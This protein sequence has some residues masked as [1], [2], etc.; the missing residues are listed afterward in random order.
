MRSI[1]S[2]TTALVAILLVA[3]CSTGGPPSTSPGDGPATSPSPVPSPSAAPSDTTTP[4]PAASPEDVWTEAAELAGVSLATVTAGGP[5]VLV[6]GCANPDPEGW[7]LEA[8]VWTSADGRTLTPA[9]V[10][11]PEGA[12]IGRIVAVPGGYVALGSERVKLAGEG[13]AL[14]RA[15]MWR[16]ADGRDWR[17]VEDETFT[18]RSLGD[19]I[20]WNGGLLALGWNAPYASEYHGFALWRSS[21]GDDWQLVSSETLPGIELVSGLL[22]GPDG[23]VAWGP[24]STWVSGSEMGGVVRSIDGIVWTRTPDQASLAKAEILGVALE[25]GRYVAVG[26]S[27]LPGEEPVVPAAWISEDGV[28]WTRVAPPSGT[29][30]GAMRDVWSTGTGFVASGW[31]MRSPD[32]DMVRTYWASTDGTDWAALEPGTFV[33]D[34]PGMEV[35]EPA[36]LGDGR[37]AVGYQSDPVRSVVWVNPA[38]GP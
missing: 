34:A 27:G 16:S 21:D 30:A 10:E 5:G 6:G 17:R 24:R 33:P 26:V 9:T 19:V 38:A 14:L 3:A 32:T 22:V 8:G 18:N 4:S 35:S 2:A 12:G 29:A 37:V 36:A 20:P 28:T 11:R 1:G 15:A 31:A 7:C 25:D 13:E 23:L